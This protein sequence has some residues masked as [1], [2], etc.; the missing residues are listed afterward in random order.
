MPVE[1]KR[2]K[3]EESSDR[4]NPIDLCRSGRVKMVDLK[5]TDL[6]GTMQHTSIPAKRVNEELI[7]AG[8][9][10]DGSSIRGFAHINESDMLLMPD[11]STAVIDP[12]CKVPTLTVT[13]N[14]Q[15][16]ISGERYSRD[17]RY[18]AAKAEDLSAKAKDTA[19]LIDKMVSR[20]II[21][22]NQAANRKS[23]VLKK[24]NSIEG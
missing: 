7:S 24:A 12:I 15:D 1:I 17:P 13:C 4:K 2:R 11:L 14:V 21:H 19:R 20:G 22:K 9:G 8:I 16:P 6:P 18:I 5:F 3:K 23:G 10:F